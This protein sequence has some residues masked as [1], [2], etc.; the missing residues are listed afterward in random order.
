MCVSILNHCHK[1]LGTSILVKSIRCTLNIAY[2]HLNMDFVVIYYN[3]LPITTANWCRTLSIRFG[4]I[5]WINNFDSQQDKSWTF[6][7]I[8]APRLWSLIH[9][10]MYINRFSIHSPHYSNCNFHI[11][12]VTFVEFKSKLL[13]TVPNIIMLI[14]SNETNPTHYSMWIHNFLGTL[15][16]NWLTQCAQTTKYTNSDWSKWK[17]KRHVSGLVI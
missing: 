9:T 16:E 6:W 8:I 4:S 15:N 5:E 3:L 10:N 12:F 11:R 17:S 14:N 13:N 1:I 7:L 2:V